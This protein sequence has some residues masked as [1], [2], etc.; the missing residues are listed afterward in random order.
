MIFDIFL[1]IVALVIIYFIRRIFSMYDELKDEFENNSV[2][3]TDQLDKIQDMFLK[4]VR[5]LDEKE[6]FIVNQLNR[7]ISIENRIN[8]LDYKLA[9][10]GWIDDKLAEINDEYL[11]Q[12]DKVIDSYKSLLNQKVADSQAFKEEFEKVKIDYNQRF[13]LEISEFKVSLWNEL[14]KEFSEMVKKLGVPT[15]KKGII[16]E[17]RMKM[18]STRFNTISTGLSANRSFYNRNFKELSE[19]ITYLENL[20]NKDA[21]KKYDKVFDFLDDKTIREGILMLKYDVSSKKQ[22]Q[23]KLG[24]VTVKTFDKEFFYVVHISELF[25]IEEILINS[26]FLKVRRK[27]PSTGILTTMYLVPRKLFYN[28]ND[29]G[30]FIIALNEIYNK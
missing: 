24:N 23:E 22:I 16:D 1:S 21:F 4:P 20:V 10:P 29:V 15:S 12:I 19:K 25:K 5:K 2:Y 28:I 11:D 9:N 3:N 30:R 17:E 7:Y 27:N 26:G 6:A 13:E 18:I 8:E 14:T